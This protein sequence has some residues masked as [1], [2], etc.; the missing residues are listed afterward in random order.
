MLSLKAS[1]LAGGR[2]SVVQRASNRNRNIL[3]SLTGA[4][5]HR[6]CATHPAPLPHDA[7]PKKKNSKPSQMEKKCLNEKVVEENT[8]S[9]TG[10]IPDIPS[11]SWSSIGFEPEDANDPNKWKKFAWKYVGAVLLFFVSYKTLHWYVDRIEEEGQQSKKNLE[12]S[13]EFSN[14]LKKGGTT[15]VNTSSMLQNAVEQNPELKRMLEPITE[16]SFQ[17]SSEL[18]E[19][20]KFRDELNAKLRELRKRG[21]NPEI[22]AEKKEVQIELKALASEIS[23]LERNKS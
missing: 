21:R 5:N 1:S 13:R 20:Y 23:T 9:D 18:E 6:H 7:P 4:I 22:D 12:E 10:K 3:E 19:L 14:E 17:T 11:N 15:S 8:R 2:T 16:S